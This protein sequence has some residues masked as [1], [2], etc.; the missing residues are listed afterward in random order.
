MSLPVARVLARDRRLDYLVGKDNRPDR[1]VTRKVD[2]VETPSFATLLSEAIKQRGLTLDRITHRLDELGFSVSAATLS[3]WQNGRSQPTRTHSQPIISALEG[4]LEMPAGSLTSAAPAQQ[5]RRRSAAGQ[6]QQT[7]PGAVEALLREAELTHHNLR[8]VSTQ[9]T[10]DLD[11][12]QSERF[13]VVRNVVK[14]LADGTDRFPIVGTVDYVDGSPTQEVQGLSNCRVGRVLE[15]P[16]RELVLTELLLPRAMARGDLMMFEYM[17][18]WASRPDP[19]ESLEVATGRMNELVLEVQ[20]DARAVPE[21]VVS[22]TRQLGQTEEPEA[23]GLG[24]VALVEGRAQCV[25]LDVS[26]GIHCLRW[27][28]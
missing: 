19:T 26:A 8:K 17:T 4:I 2:K 14:C 21:R 10:L 1:G 20:F 18:T 11:E 7:L 16:E 3:Y 24:A 15:V 27:Q 23:P 28:W 22:F 13:E 5:V 12:G 9:V 6:S 25:R